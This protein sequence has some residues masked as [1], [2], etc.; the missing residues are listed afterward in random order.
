MNEDRNTVVTWYTALL[1]GGWSSQTC[2][3]INRR[4]AFPSTP[5]PF[6]HPNPCTSMYE[7]VY[8]QTS[9]RGHALASSNCPF[10]H[11]DFSSRFFFWNFLNCDWM[12][13]AAFSVSGSSMS[14]S[15]SS[16]T[17]D[18]DTSG[19]ERECQTVTVF[20]CSCP[21]I[22]LMFC[23]VYLTMG[24]Q[25][26]RSTKRKTFVWHFYHKFSSQSLV[27]L[28]YRWKHN[29]KNEIIKAERVLYLTV[30]AALKLHNSNN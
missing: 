29:E 5:V 14:M 9:R 24:T 3:M 23:C 12:V 26:R 30:N 25:R 16:G 2:H 21:V 13:T 19:G 11:Y 10:A 27:M 15:K 7:F 6:P 1:I 22:P 17:F 8:M 20:T 28:S 4:F 18:L